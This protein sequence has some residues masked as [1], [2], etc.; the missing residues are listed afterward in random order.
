M[1]FGVHLLLYSSDPEADRAF[2]RDVLEFPAVDAGHGWLIFALPPAEMAIHPADS[3]PA[4]GQD[5]AAAKVYLMCE[6]LAQATDRLTAKGIAHAEIQEARWGTVT[7]IALPGGGRV[8]L[9]E[10]HHPLAISAKGNDAGKDPA[11]G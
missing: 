7:S 6:N 1:F 5:L 4:A 8:G 11:Q 9:Y 3:A 2:V 10:P